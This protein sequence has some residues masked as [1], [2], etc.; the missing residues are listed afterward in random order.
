MIIKQITA[1]IVNAIQRGD[2]THHQDQLIIPANLSTRNI[3]NS[4]VGIFA[5]VEL[6]VLII[7]YFY[8]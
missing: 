7:L 3:K 5:P 1:T 8:K 2:V 4:T 6:F